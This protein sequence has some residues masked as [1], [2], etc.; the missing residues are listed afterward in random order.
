MCR[1]HPSLR[2][3]TPTLDPAS[4]EMVLPFLVGPHRMGRKD[5]GLLRK[6]D[7]LSDEHHDLYLLPCESK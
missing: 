4:A 3:S 2:L 6:R 5:P 7:G 1:D